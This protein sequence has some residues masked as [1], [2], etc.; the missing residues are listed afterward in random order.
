M[1]NLEEITR[2][3]DYWISRIQLDLYHEVRSYLNKNGM[4]QS[5][6]AAQLGVSKGYIS[7]LMN[8]NFDHKLSKLIKLSLAI[9][10]VPELEF[11]AVDELVARARS[12]ASSGTYE[13][14]AD[15]VPI[16]DNYFPEYTEDDDQC[17][18]VSFYQAA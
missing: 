18:I 5:D 4:R 16:D 8:G 12:E 15:I 13:V 10:K 17:R 1:F 11:T 6:F 2:S 7:Q 9:G 3:P 14:E